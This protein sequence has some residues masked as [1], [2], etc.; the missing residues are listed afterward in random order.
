M[1][2]QLKYIWVITRNTLILILLLEI[3][4]G[5]IYNYKSKKEYNAY[6]D[7]KINAKVHEDMNKEAIR[8]MY[9]EY[10]DVEMQWEPFHHYIPKPF[11]GMY[12]NIDALGR[13]KTLQYANHNTKDTITIF[14]F[15]GSTMYGIGAT[16]STT[17]AS[18]LSKQ[19]SKSYP[20]QNF[21][22]INFGVTGYNRDQETIQLNQELINGNIPNIVI[23][24]DGVNEALCGYQNKTVGLPPS[25]SSRMLEFN[26]SKFYGK[27]SNLFFETS[28][29]NKLI[30]YLKN[31]LSSKNYTVDS[32]E[33]AKTIAVNYQ[34]H[35]TYSEAL[36]KIYDFK[37]FNFLQPT[38]FTKQKLTEFEVIMKNNESY[39]EDIFKNTYRIITNDTLLNQNNSFINMSQL[40]DGYDHVIFTDFCHTAEKGNTIIAEEISAYISED[41]VIKYRDSTP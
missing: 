7:L 29:T 26:T 40:F 33:L 37:V 6:I 36:S 2:K 19:L 5:V 24:F 13:R 41:L 22:I 27:K 17:I 20:N 35:V 12:N 9:F 39:L 14:C 15:G 16:D 32:E 10:L 8:A 11:K 28:N 4:L 3:I 31:K 1:I 34:N 23:F 25:A 38:I 21:D 18:L 30:T